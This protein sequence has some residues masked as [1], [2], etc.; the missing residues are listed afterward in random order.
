MAYVCY[1]RPPHSGAMHTDD[2]YELTPRAQAELSSAATGLAPAEIAL[3]VRFDGLL[4]LRQVQASLAPSARA[5]FEATVRELRD[6]QL[7]ALVELDPFSSR[8]QVEVGHFA[9]LLGGEEEETD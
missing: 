3:L 4:T 5:R 6:R 2:I 9:A 7:L 1:T 8:F